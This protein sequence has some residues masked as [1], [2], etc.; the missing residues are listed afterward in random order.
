[1]REF[2]GYCVSS[3]EYH[4]MYVLEAQQNA[5]LREKAVL[6][7]NIILA[8]Q[9]EL[10][11]T[12]Q[13]LS[14]K[15]ATV[16]GL[17]G[18]LE[19]QKKE[20]EEWVEKFELQDLKTE[21]AHQRRIEEE[22]KVY[23][24][25]KVALALRA[26]MEKMNSVQVILGG[27]VRSF[28]QKVEDQRSVIEDK[29]IVNQQLAAKVNDLTI[30]CQE[31]NTKTDI[32]ASIIR[33]LKSTVDE[34]NQKLSECNDFITFVREREG[35]L[36]ERLG[37]LEEYYQAKRHQRCMLFRQNNRRQSHPAEEIILC[38]GKLLVKEK[39]ETISSTAAVRQVM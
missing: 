7:S 39:F 20:T 32:D 13:E 6:Q 19:H 2:N 1:M 15:N 38:I 9:R 24:L 25:E 18:Q 28:K 3:E 12:K 14:I 21:R 27:Q 22:Q 11:A 34:Q 37:Q 33:A 16:E 29:E 17:Q 26:E 23:R 36:S 5:E 4:Q 30:L 35:K 10:A 31:A 8:L